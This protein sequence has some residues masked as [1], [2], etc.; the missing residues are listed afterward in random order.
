[1]QNNIPDGL[2]DAIV[3]AVCNTHDGSDLW[4]H[5]KQDPNAFRNAVRWAIE[6]YPSTL[7]VCVCGKARAAGVHQDPSHGHAFTP[8]SVIAERLVDERLA[9]AR[10]AAIG[11]FK[12]TDPTK[13][14]A[15]L[16]ALYQLLDIPWPERIEERIEV[17]QTVKMFN[18]MLSVHTPDEQLAI[19]IDVLKAHWKGG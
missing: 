4:K 15:H 13:V 18:A 1:M 19:V 2:I 17:W 12:E 11:V 16:K 10:T 3:S 7:E 8:N 6:F 5:A 14:S 9:A